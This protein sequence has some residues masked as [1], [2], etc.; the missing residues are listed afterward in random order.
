MAIGYKRA[1]EMADIDLDVHH[2][3]ALLKAGAL[4]TAILNAEVRR[5]MAGRKAVA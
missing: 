2:T 4:Q 1:R 3:E 5:A